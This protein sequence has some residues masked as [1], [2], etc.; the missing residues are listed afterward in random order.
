MEPVYILFAGINGAGKSTFFHENFWNVDTLAAKRNRVNPDEILVDFG[1][2]SNSQNDQLK[3]AKI[4]V[5]RI[6][7]FI[8]SKKSFNQETTLTGKTSIKTIQ[9]A[10]E[11]GYKVIIYYINVDS[12]GTAIARISH[13]VETG[14]HDIE[15]G[16]VKRRYDKSLVQFSKALDYVDE[17]YLYDNTTSFRLAA[18]WSEGTLYWVG[19]PKV[20]KPWINYVLANNLWE[21]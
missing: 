3:A 9:K 4:A 7:E 16:V 2:D 17:A 18:A 13:R 1:G 10:K 6:N 11:A 14:G 15:P 19:N 20:Y 12:I 21:R 8:S 5:K